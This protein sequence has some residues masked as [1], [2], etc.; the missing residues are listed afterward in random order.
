M[1]R[2]T[3]ATVDWDDGTT[4]AVGG[5]NLK[6]GFKKYATQT[7]KASRI[8]ARNESRQ[9]IFWDFFSGYATM[10]SSFER[11]GW[12]TLTVDS[13]KHFWRKNPDGIKME[14]KPSLQIDILHLTEADIKDLAKTHGFSGSA[15]FEPPCSPRS[16]QPKTGIIQAISQQ[17]GNLRGGK[18]AGACVTE[19]LF[20][21]RD[22][23]AVESSSAAFC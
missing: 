1:E 16:R 4:T 18:Q 15:H 17:H 3:Q 9:P 23:E 21:Y 6:R 19:V 7:S 11:R 8:K 12:Q 2:N 14:V 22:F 10:P 5:R 20:H 13:A